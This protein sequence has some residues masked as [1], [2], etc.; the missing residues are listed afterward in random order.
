MQEFINKETSRDA[1]CLL[2]TI[3]KGDF[4]ICMVI[5]AEMFA[6]GE[7]ICRHFQRIELDLCELVNIASDLTN[8]LKV[9]RENA[10]ENFKRLF[11]YAQNLVSSNGVE[12]NCRAF[13][14]N[15]HIAQIR[16]SA[17]M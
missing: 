16:T 7:P 9:M 10:D 4:I 2:A 11:I 14:E 12:I 17:T 6:L 15:K 1:M 5:L 8:E 13:Q 3:T